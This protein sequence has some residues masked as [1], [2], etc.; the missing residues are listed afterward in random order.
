MQDAMPNSIARVNVRFGDRQRVEQH[1]ADA[2][3]PAQPG[4]ASFAE[5]VNESV[6]E[7]DAGAAIAGARGA[8]AREHARAADSGA[9]ACR[10]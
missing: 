3:R 8:V 4:A 7:R 5:Q 2:A 1:H 10:R 6:R 9:S